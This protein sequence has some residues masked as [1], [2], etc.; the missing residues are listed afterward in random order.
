MEKRID[1][2]SELVNRLY[3]LGYPAQVGTNDYL[4][5]GNFINSNFNKILGDHSFNED[6]VELIRSQFFMTITST[7]YP[8]PIVIEV[9]REDSRVILTAT[10]DQN[11]EELFRITK[12]GDKVTNLFFDRENFI[13]HEYVVE[14]L[15]D[16]N[17]TY[18]KSEV[19][20]ENRNV[21]FSGALKALCAKYRDREVFELTRIVP[22]EHK[23]DS[24]LKRIVDGIKG[25]NFIQIVTSNQIYETVM[26]TDIIFD[27]LE[28]ECKKSEAKA[29]EEQRKLQKK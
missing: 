25:E 11:G 28:M 26:Y 22:P 15:V 17:F 9:N 13:E 12:E 20:G 4:V 8:V 21:V 1:I 24:L 16:P 2:T 6:D 5:I 18:T 23:E 29:L 7:F 19:D 10:A 14:G 3:S 27:R